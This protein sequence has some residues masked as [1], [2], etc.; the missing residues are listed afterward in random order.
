VNLTKPGQIACFNGPGRHVPRELAGRDAVT[1]ETEGQR[2]KREAGCEDP[3]CGWHVGPY[4]MPAENPL[5]RSLRAFMGF[6]IIT[7]DA[8]AR[9]ERNQ[10][11]FFMGRRK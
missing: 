8:L 1:V 4:C 6:Q 5:V 9:S 7:K 11:F 10:D 3:A 2:L